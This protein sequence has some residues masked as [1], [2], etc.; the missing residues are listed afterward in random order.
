MLTLPA[1]AEKVIP[2]A[3]IVPGPNPRRYFSPEALEELTNSIRARGILQRIIVR[4]MASG[5]DYEIVAGERRYR[6]AVAA[7][8]PEH[9]I[10]VNV[11]EYTDEQALLVSIE[12][13]EQRENPSE[14]EQADGALRLLEMLN[15]DRAETARRLGWP[16]SKFD[17]RIALTKL[18]QTVKTALDERRIM[19]GHAELLAAVAPDKQEKALASILDNDLSVARTRELLAR[20]THSL[21]DAKFD[22]TQCQ[23][24][25]F[26]SASQRALFATCVDDGLCTNPSCYETKVQQHNMLEEARLKEEAERKKAAEPKPAPLKKPATAPVVARTAAPA[27]AD[28]VSARAPSAEEYSPVPAAASAAPGTAPSVDESS[29]EP[30]AAP[31]VA[32]PV[33]ADHLAK[34]REQIIRKSRETRENTWR[35]ATTHSVMTSDDFEMA[36][37]VILLAAFQGDINEIR[38]NVLSSRSAK[39]VGEGFDEA[40]RADRLAMISKLDDAARKRALKAIATAYVQKTTRF[41]NVATIAGFYGTE[42]SDH[43]S[44]TAEFLKLYTKTEIR[45]IAIELGVADHVGPKAFAKMCGGKVGEFIAGLLAIPGFDWARRIPSA[46]SLTGEASVPAAASLPAAA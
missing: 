42:L 40:A 8:G 2:L 14:T 27:A 4:P 1:L 10:V 26:N 24:C 32:E 25:P 9:E 5:D 21:A 33:D 6:A 28:A 3:R 13:N 18:L 30:E 39:F 17:R 20:L 15:G 7:W 41:D 16:R 23:T 22:L 44:V 37:S 31:E 45:F 12:E 11:G 34:F 29:S 43:W 36:N 35:K 38:D 19:L 46:M